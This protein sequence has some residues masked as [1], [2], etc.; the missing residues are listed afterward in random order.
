MKI[1]TLFTA[2][3][4]GAASL[5]AQDPI[6]IVIPSDPYCDETGCYGHP[7]PPT[8][9]DETGCKY[10]LAVS[11]KTSVT[12]GKAAH[13]L[14]GP[15]IGIQVYVGGVLQPEFSH[16]DSINQS[17]YAVTVSWPQSFSGNVKLGGLFPSNSSSSED[18]KPAI[19]GS[20]YPNQLKICPGCNKTNAVAVRAVN[21]VRYVGMGAVVYTHVLGAGYSALRAYVEGNKLVFGLNGPSSGWGSFTGSCAGANCKVSHNIASFPSGAVQLATCDLA[22]GQIMAC[23][24]NRPW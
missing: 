22:N 4:L 15:A 23:T 11:N 13:G 10:N 20:P 19:D 7:D 2:L 5:V 6:I 17:T 8:D 12:I 9:C 21:G 3:L 14:D 24:D 18:F 16:T 1:I